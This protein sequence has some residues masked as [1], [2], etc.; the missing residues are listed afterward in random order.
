MFTDISLRVS[1][2]EGCT[3]AKPACSFSWRLALEW[4]V[5]SGNLH[6]EGWGWNHRKTPAYER[7]ALDVMQ[8]QCAI[9]FSVLAKKWM[10]LCGNPFL[11][12]LRIRSDLEDSSLFLS[13]RRTL[14]GSVKDAGGTSCWWEIVWIVFTFS[15][16][17]AAWIMLFLHTTDEE[18]FQDEKQKDSFWDM[19]VRKCRAL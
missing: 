13:K 8:K 17:F 18:Y 3:F 14:C 15:E 12:L 5:S 1:G 9:V 2:W 11:S 6:R 7:A 4:C 19:R 10:W 16:M